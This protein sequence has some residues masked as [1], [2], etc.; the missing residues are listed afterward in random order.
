MVSALLATAQP[1]GAVGTL[2]TLDHCWWWPGNTTVRWDQAWLLKYYRSNFVTKVQFLWNDGFQSSG[3]GVIEG[4][5]A[6]A[7]TPI[8]AT[9]AQAELFLGSGQTV[10]TYTADCVFH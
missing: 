4:D 10:L 7:T 9:T 3:L 8:G 5:S 2:P 6:R 1:A